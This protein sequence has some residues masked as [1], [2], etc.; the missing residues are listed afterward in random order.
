MNEV[1]QKSTIFPNEEAS[2]LHTQTD[3]AY[4]NIANSPERWFYIIFGLKAPHRQIN[5]RTN[6]EGKAI[7][8]DLS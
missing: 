7:C 6:T 1:S 8:G 4:N 5:I 3:S 2:N